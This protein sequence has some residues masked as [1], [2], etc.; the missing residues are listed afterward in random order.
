MKEYFASLQLF[1]AVSISDWFHN[2]SDFY[3]WRIWENCCTI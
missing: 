2:C 1:L 3:V